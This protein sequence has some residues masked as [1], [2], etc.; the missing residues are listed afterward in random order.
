MNDYSKI[1]NSESLNL[2]EETIEISHNCLVD[3]SDV[4]YRY[5]VLFERIEVLRALN[6]TAKLL[7]QK[8]CFRLD[9][10]QKEALL[11][12]MSFLND[13]DY[14]LDFHMFCELPRKKVIHYNPWSIMVAFK[15]YRDRVVEPAKRL[16]PDF[17]KYLEDTE[18]LLNQAIDQIEKRITIIIPGRI[19]IAKNSI[20]DK[21]IIL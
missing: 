12:Y 17:K 3:I 13:K 5:Q 21:K 20:F 11:F 19:K 1:L 16:Y 6:I 18:V 14:Q 15:I 7:F 10:K 4:L 8:K 2:L 9:N